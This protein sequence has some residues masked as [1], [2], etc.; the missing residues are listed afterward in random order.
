MFVSVGRPQK[1]WTRLIVANLH[2]AHTLNKAES[3]VAGGNAD[4]RGHE[5]TR[6]ASVVGHGPCHDAEDGRDGAD[7][8][9]PHVGL[10]LMRL[11]PDD[12]WEVHDNIDEESNEIL[13]V[14]TGTKSNNSQLLFVSMSQ[15]QC[16]YLSGKVLAMSLY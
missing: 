3:S 13:G 12:D 1:T 8:S 15:E 14:S 2:A 4:G 10:E 9:W 7:E 11:D 5:I 16:P 6:C